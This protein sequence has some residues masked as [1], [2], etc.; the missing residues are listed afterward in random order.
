MGSDANLDADIR[1]GSADEWDQS[2]DRS[3]EA[4][5]CAKLE[6]RLSP[7]EAAVRCMLCATKKSEVTKK[8]PA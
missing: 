5:W 2:P 7:M 4:K 1:V 8:I 3:I 6:M